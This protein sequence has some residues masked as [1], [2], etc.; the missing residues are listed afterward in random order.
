[1]L[2][3]LP[4]VIATF[5]ALTHLLC[6][7]IRRIKDDVLAMSLSG[8]VE[9]V[10]VA[11]KPANHFDW[12]LNTEKHPDLRIIDCYYIDRPVIVAIGNLLRMVGSS[13]EHLHLP[14]V[15]DLHHGEGFTFFCTPSTSKL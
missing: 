14:P 11:S 2:V 4:A 9:A 1:V 10:D 7:Y 3:R 15:Y 6:P 8:S 13:L 5:P 12:S